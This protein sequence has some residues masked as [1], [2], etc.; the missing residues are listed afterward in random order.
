MRLIELD[1]AKWANVLDFYH[2]LLAALGS[3]E[4]H[5]TGIDALLDS[6]IW[7]DNINQIHPP[8]I[9]RIHGA[10]SLSK[11]VLDEVGLLKQS[12]A[13]ARAESVSRRGRD[14]NINIEL[15]DN[16]A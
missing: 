11:D 15:V 3:P 14:V 12:V 2:A 10:K 6:M 16:D 5:G 4:W 9:I 13:E 8:Y 1:G 7:H